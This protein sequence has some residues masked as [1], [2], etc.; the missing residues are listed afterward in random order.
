MTTPAK[1]ALPL[2]MYA[3]KSSNGD[4]HL[5]RDVE[6]TNHVCTWQSWLKNKPDRR[7]KWV[8]CN[9]SRYRLVW[10]K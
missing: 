3:V 6:A 8:N 10:L 2:S 5:F 4:V 9:C 7:F 1:P